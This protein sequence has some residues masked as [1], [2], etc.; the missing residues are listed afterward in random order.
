MFRLV[1]IFLL[2]ATGVLSGLITYLI[3]WVVLPRKPKADYAI[4]E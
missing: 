3:A 4:I 1:S 2:I